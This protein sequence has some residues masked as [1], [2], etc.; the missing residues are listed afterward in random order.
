MDNGKILV[1][2]DN[3]TYILKFIGDV[4]LTLCATLDEFLL[5]MSNDENLTA[6]FI[7]LSETQ[8]ID[9]TSLG[10]LAK[11]S[12]FCRKKFQLIPTIIST[13]PDITRILQSMGFERVFIILEQAQT[14]VETL[15]EL[16]LITQSEEVVKTKVIEAHKILMDMNEKNKET[17][18]ELV[19]T[20]EGE[21][22]SD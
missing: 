14:P 19:Y 11:I 7:D 16:P 5:S 3:G 1:S 6:V 12:V 20:L 13:S 2:E 18:K 17:F 21:K 10:L 8:G 9:S 4:R 22:P 15:H